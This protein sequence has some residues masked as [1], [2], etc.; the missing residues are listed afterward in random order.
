MKNTKAEN[1]T[2]FSLYFLIGLM[3]FLNLLF[4]YLILRKPNNNLS[5]EVPKKAEKIEKRII[6]SQVS[7]AS[8]MTL[9]FTGDVI[10]ARSVNAMM[11]RKNNFNFPFEKTADFLKSGDLTI[12][13]LESPL[14][15][16]CPTT[17]EGMVFCGDPRF[18]TG[19]NYAGVDIANL[20]NNHSSNYGEEGI[21]STKEKLNKIGIETVGT[22]N[23]VYRNVKG[24]NLAFLSYDG[25]APL[26]PF[27]SNINTEL[28]KSQVKEAKSQ[29]DFVIVLFHW[30][31]EYEKNPVEEKSVAPFNPVE[32]G[33][34]TIDSGADLV[35]GNHPHVV[36]GYEIYNGK[37]IFYA[38]GNFIFD[39]MWSEETKIGAPL[40]LE[41][42][43][44]KVQNFSFYPEK[45]ENFAQPYF[46]E[47]DEK[48]KVLEKIIR[49]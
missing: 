26:V 22:G 21:V 46:L 32:I 37:Y 45:I 27:L 3:F 4:F 29:A 36:Q 11:V 34:Y 9:I 18:T 40:K 14:I 39:Q 49:Y 13:N 6:A 5:L 42:V 1:R 17:D 2:Y 12:I 47:G 7:S 19:L 20:A 44:G 41:I 15:D 31:K 33:R 24:T 25:V 10:P 35:V 48:E 28:I 16:H 8:S 38:L 43:N 30:G 23:I